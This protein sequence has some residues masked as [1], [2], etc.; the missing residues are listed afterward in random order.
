MDW[1]L[2]FSTKSTAK[3]IFQKAKSVIY[4]MRV[5]LKQISNLSKDVY[6]V[7]TTAAS[8]HFAIKNHTFNK[9]SSL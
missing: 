6:K 4:N 3:A 9:E 2:Q 7:D 5:R 1:Y 8:Y